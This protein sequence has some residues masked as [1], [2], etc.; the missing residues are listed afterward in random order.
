MYRYETHLHTC[1]GS[2][3]GVSTGAEHARFYQ[4]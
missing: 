2:A 1:Q 4:E 3:C